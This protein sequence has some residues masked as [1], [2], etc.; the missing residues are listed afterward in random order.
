[1]P[2]MHEKKKRLLVVLGPFVCCV[3]AGATSIHSY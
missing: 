1:M 3:S 2:G